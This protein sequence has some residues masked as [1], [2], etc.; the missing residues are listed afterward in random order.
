[1]TGQY[2]VAVAGGVESIG[3]VQEHLNGFMAEDPWLRANVPSVYLPMLQT[4]E[5]VA[6]RY[7]ISRERQDEYGLQ[8][9]LRSAAAAAADP[10]TLRFAARCPDSSPRRVASFS[11]SSHSAIDERRNL[12]TGMSL[13]FGPVIGGRPRRGFFG[14]MV[15][16]LSVGISPSTRAR[17]RA[18]TPV[19]RVPS[20]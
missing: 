3:L 5:V 12:T 8:S 2:D 13:F 19:N 18:A 11:S 9:Q 7:A 20:S 16:S 17:V 15:V 1:M 14:A 6:E 4:A 10:D